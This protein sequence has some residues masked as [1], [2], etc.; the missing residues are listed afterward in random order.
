VSAAFDVADDLALAEE[1]ARTAG[2]V[3]LRAFGRPPSGLATKSTETDLV[4][5]ADRDAERVISELLRVERPDDG[6]LGEEGDARAGSSGR[7]WVVDPLDG[8]VNFVYGIPAWAV[9]VAVEDG[10]GV[11]AGVVHDPVRAETFSA[12]RGRGAAL[13]GVPIRVREPE[14]LSKAMVATG[15][16]YAAELRTRQAETLMRVLPAV[17][18]VRRMGAAALDLS[19]VAAG[20]F[21]GYYERGLNAWDWAAGSLLVLEAGGEL[22]QL[23]GEPAGLVATAP[24][25]L[26]GLLELVRD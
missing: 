26:E 3:L 17:R 10:D 22:A 15:F 2:H 12:A 8:T 1:A 21:D 25:L 7:R 20:R 11:L 18:D 24:G 19:W 5:D 6:V 14:G 13:D 9:S 4:T 16:S 23:E